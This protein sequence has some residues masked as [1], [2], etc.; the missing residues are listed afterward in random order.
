MYTWLHWQ[1]GCKKNQQNKAFLLSVVD[2]ELLVRDSGGV[3]VLLFVPGLP[4]LCST[5]VGVPSLMVL[6]N[7]NAFHP[8]PHKNKSMAILAPPW[9]LVDK[10]IDLVSEFSDPRTA[11][12]SRRVSRMWQRTLD[13][14]DS[15]FWKHVVLH[16]L[17][18]FSKS[19]SLMEILCP[20][21]S[22]LRNY[23]IH[24]LRNTQTIQHVIIFDVAGRP[25]QWLTNLPLDDCTEHLY[26]II[27][28]TIKP[29]AEDFTLLLAGFPLPRSK[30]IRTFQHPALADCKR[31]QWTLDAPLVI[32][33][34]WCEEERQCPIP[35]DYEQLKGCFIG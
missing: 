20:A 31:K 30:T 29:L 13:Q 24:S 8:P 16:C 9:Y 14:M 6:F 10:L 12:L 19:T 35:M 17:P 25:L 2:V 5:S 3:V 27:Q 18:Q 32:Q 23:S 4:S 28:R 7:L 21:F 15:S 22:Q 33:H 11:F 1:N 26:N 34:Y